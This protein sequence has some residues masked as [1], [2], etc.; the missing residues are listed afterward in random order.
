M[1]AF[2]I[3]FISRVIALVEASILLTQIEIYRSLPSSQRRALRINEIVLIE[4]FG[5]EINWN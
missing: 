1:L 5:I 2:A 3:A 4:H